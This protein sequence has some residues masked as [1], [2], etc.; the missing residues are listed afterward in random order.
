MRRKIDIKGIVVARKLPESFGDRSQILFLYFCT[1]ILVQ[2]PQRWQAHRR[3][4]AAPQKPEDGDPDKR[5]VET[6]PS[7]AHLNAQG[8]PHRTAEPGSRLPRAPCFH[9]RS[10]SM[11][12][13]SSAL[14]LSVTRVAT[15]EACAHLKASN[16]RERQRRPKRNGEAAKGPGSLFTTACHRAKGRSIRRECE[17]RSDC[18]RHGSAHG[19]SQRT[20]GSGTCSHPQEGES[21]RRRWRRA[22]GCAVAACRLLD[23]VAAVLH[24]VAEPCE[25]QELEVVVAVAERDDARGLHAERVAQPAQPDALVD[26]RVEH[27]HEK[28]R[29][30]TDQLGRAGRQ[31]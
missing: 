17:R 10:S 25:L 12:T 2:V 3:A 16:N 22:C 15:C 28:G 8:T 30:A 7:A 24:G 9:R 18:V 14:L 29:R 21:Q 20:E 13:P 27:L 6:S 19:D 4:R 26:A 5:C 11:A 31:L 1:S 23:R